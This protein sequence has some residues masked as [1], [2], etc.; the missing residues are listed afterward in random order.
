MARWYQPV[1]CHYDHILFLL[2][3]C[4][5][6]LQSW[7]ISFVL[8]F[9]Q[10]NIDFRL[11]FPDAVNTFIDEFPTW[12]RGVIAMARLSRKADIIELLRDYDSQEH[13]AELSL[14]DYLYA[15]LALLYLLPSADTRHKAKLSAAELP[16][17]FIWFKPQQT[18]IDLFLSEKNPQ[19]H[20]QP[21]LLCLGT[22]ECP[23][24]F[25]LIL[26]MKAIPLGDCGVLKAV[27]AFFKSHYVFYVGYAKCLETFMEFLQKLVYKIECTKLSGRVRELQNS[28][29][30]FQV[31]SSQTI[32]WLLGTGVD[33]DTF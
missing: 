9:L 5:A 24:A 31:G 3:P 21:F 10:L 26:D 32:N 2:L 8:C 33:A 18:G 14:R 12:A 27:D 1:K 11:H 25:Y 7:V 15:L 29:S 17:R 30:S 19:T 20:K 28:I 4:D 23:G 22:R 16:N 13:P 6:R